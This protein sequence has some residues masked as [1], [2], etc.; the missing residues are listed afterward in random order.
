MASSL[1]IG[2]PEFLTLNQHGTRAVQLLDL[3]SVTD[4]STPKGRINLNTA[5]SEVLRT[6]AAGIFLN[7]DPDILPNSL[8]KKLRGPSI[9]KEAD[10]FAEAVIQSRPFL[11]TSQL[12]LIQLNGKP[13]FGN[14]EIWPEAERPTEWNDAGREA[15]FTKIFELACTKSRNFRIYITAEVL[16]P[17]RAV[18]ARC[19]K[20]YQVNLEP[21]RNDAKAIIRQKVNLIYTS[22]L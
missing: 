16:D 19:R 21:I 13:F 17:K 11:S 8:Q 20:V 15:Y 1:R 6:L 14:P 10:R 18:R 2:R 12:A 7:N 3:F 22:N 4:E 9:S 5:S